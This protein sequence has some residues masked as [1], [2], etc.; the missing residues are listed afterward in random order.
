MSWEQQTVKPDQRRSWYRG[1]AGFALS[2]TLITSLI[3]LILVVGSLYNK[4]P[5]T[6]NLTPNNTATSNL[7][8]F[9]CHLSYD[10]APFT[11]AVDI[12]LT[13]WMN[14]DEAILVAN[15]LFDN[16]L[17][18]SG[19]P[20]QLK[21]AD[22]HELGIWTVELIWGYSTADLMHWFEAEIDPFNR[23]IL[24]YHCK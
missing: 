12:N 11:I 4:N 3:A 8:N 2:V 17:G 10:G 21:S 24:Y 5:T 14:R 6:S 13:D 9:T 19:E 22:M 16:T 1:W 20:H 15:T 18:Q 7:V 23:T